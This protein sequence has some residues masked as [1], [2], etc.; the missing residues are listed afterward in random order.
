MN[1]SELLHGNNNDLSD[2]DLAHLADWATAWKDN[3]PNPS[4]KRAYALIREGADLLLRRRAMCAEVFENHVGQLPSVEEEPVL[5]PGRAV[6][7]RGQHTDEVYT[8]K[9]N[10]ISNN[11]TFYRLNNLSGLFLR[12]S[13]D[14][15]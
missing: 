1:L 9:N 2:H 5:E 4:W 11:L 3:T 14:V 10:E 6:R 7:V 15:L 13:L 8:I 12:S